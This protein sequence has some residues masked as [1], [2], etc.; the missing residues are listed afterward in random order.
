MGIISYHQFV[1]TAVHS[2]DFVD[3]DDIDVLHQKE[4]EL[5]FNKLSENNI[6]L[7]K[8]KDDLGKQLG[9]RTAEKAAVEK[10]LAKFK[11]EANSTEFVL[12]GKLVSRETFKKKKIPLHSNRAR[13]QLLY[14]NIKS[15]T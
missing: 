9:T 4:L 6:Q 1:K 14:I 12:K 8:E 7:R 3:T 5:N 11:T 10:E 13:N 15:G 2:D